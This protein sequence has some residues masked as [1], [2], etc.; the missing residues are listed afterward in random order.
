MKANDDSRVCNYLKNK[1]NAD[2][3]E[4][5][6]SNHDV[7]DVYIRSVYATEYNFDLIPKQYDSLIEVFA[8]INGEGRE[9][10]LA[11]D[12][13]REEYENL[14]FAGNPPEYITIRKRR[15]ILVDKDGNVICNMKYR[16]ASTSGYTINVIDTSDHANSFVK[17][18]FYIRGANNNLGVSDI[19]GNVIIP[20][21]FGSLKLHNRSSTCYLDEGSF[22][23]FSPIQDFYKKLASYDKEKLRELVAHLNEDDEFQIQRAIFR[24]SV[25]I[26]FDC[27]AFVIGSTNDDW[28]YYKNNVDE[29]MLLTKDNFLRI[30]DTMDWDK[31]KKQVESE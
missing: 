12:K 1:F 15:D 20:P 28:N 7:Y 3:V 31:Y 5:L 25:F 22:C 11:G 16:L 4:R 10:P 9:L 24:G 21:I 18:V 14:V 8:V 6:S 26:S 17:E 29:T 19:F 2:S 13:T 23:H 30:I 27:Y